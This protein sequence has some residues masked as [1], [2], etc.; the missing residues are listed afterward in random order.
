MGAL[1]KMLQTWWMQS[2][3]DENLEERTVT[4]LYDVEADWDMTKPA[5]LRGVSDWTDFSGPRAD[6]LL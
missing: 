2:F 4:Q 1:T 6:R 3:S 5:N